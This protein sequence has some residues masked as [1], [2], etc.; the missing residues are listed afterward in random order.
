[1]EDGPAEYYMRKEAEA[2]AWRDLL[3]YARRINAPQRVLAII[4][5]ALDMAEDTGD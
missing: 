1:M 2:K 4:V 3:A 5:K